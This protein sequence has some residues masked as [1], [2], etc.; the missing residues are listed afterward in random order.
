MC[1]QEPE[2]QVEAEAP[3]E[4]AVLGDEEEEVPRQPGRRRSTRRSDVSALE[5]CNQQRAEEE[6]PQTVEEGEEE[7]PESL[8]ASIE[9]E[10]D[11]EAGEW[12]PFE[13]ARAFV[14]SLR[15]PRNKG[16]PRKVFWMERKKPGSALSTHPGIH[17]NPPRIYGKSNDG[18]DSGW[19][20]WEDFV[21]GYEA[22]SGEQPV[23]QVEAEAPTEAAALGDE[24]EEV[25]T[26][27]GR[28]RSTRRSSVSALKDCNQQ[29][30]EEERPQAVD[31]GEEHPDALGASVEGEKD[32][33]AGEWLPFEEAR[34][35]VWS[36]RLPRNKGNPQKVFWM[37][38]KKPGSALSTHPG[39]HGN[40][41]RI[42]G[43][44]NDGED[45][46]W[47]GWEDFVYGYEAVS[48]Q[49]PEQQVEAEAPTEAAVLG[50]KKEEVLRQPGRRRS[51]RRSSVSALEDCN[52]QRRR[53]SAAG[54]R[55]E[56][57]SYEE[58]RELVRSLYLRSAN[59]SCSARAA[60]NKW[61]Q[62][63]KTKRKNVRLPTAP[64]RVY[65][66]D[67]FDWDDFVGGGAAERASAVEEAAT[68]AGA[69]CE[70][71]HE[72]S[73]A[74]EECLE[75]PPPASVSEGSEHKQKRRKSSA[76]G[77]K[78]T[79]WLPFEEARAFVWTFDLRSVYPSNAARTAWEK[80]WMANRNRRLE[81][82]LPTNPGSVYANEKGF[83]WDDFVF[84][85]TEKGEASGAAS[86][87]GKL[88][89]KR[90]RQQEETQEAPER[91]RRRSGSANKT[92]VTSAGV[93]LPRQLYK[94]YDIKGQV[95][96]VTGE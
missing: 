11:S 48:G 42:Y 26:Q 83:D 19:T 41:P 29:R 2:Q 34:A 55:V 3:A 12:L 24:E 82:R 46:G 33:D 67:G 93:E 44:S 47:T 59:P 73:R 23:Q 80:W 91:P 61:C 22:L 84:G 96:I 65:K 5:A 62:T 53:S 77:K 88:T 95:A 63:N 56:W 28:R 35:F 15:L 30:A 78:S 32:A 43:K 18:E 57:L 16:N 71:E 13:E 90:P 36:L 89:R 45:S 39:I 76:A 81:L 72:D 70:E 51:T 69:V 66:E 68:E 8:Q 52:Q 64:H 86:N 85:S 10:K 79:D 92:S 17:G 74:A 1:L 20:G 50:D 60:W 37:E 38:R 14:W 31:E 75:E 87:P 27:P 94:T 21:Y 9:G 54:D 49:R 25:L 7:H 6:R 40:P 4:A 58:A